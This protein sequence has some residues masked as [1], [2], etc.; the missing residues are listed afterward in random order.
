MTFFSTSD[1]KDHIET[2]KSL[3][4]EIIQINLDSAN[5]KYEKA[6]DKILNLIQND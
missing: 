5:Q 2:L 3:H 1:D 6:Y 4:I